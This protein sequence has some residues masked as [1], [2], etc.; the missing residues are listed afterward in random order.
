[1]NFGVLNWLNASLEEHKLFI[2]ECHTFWSNIFRE[3][4][5]FY[6]IEYDTVKGI[7]GRPV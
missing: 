2:V 7:T 5:F 1:M 6:L 4:V 3:Q